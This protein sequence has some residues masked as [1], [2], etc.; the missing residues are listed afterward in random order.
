VV[1]HQ[2]TI[3]IPA[4]GNPGLKGQS[5]LAQPSG[6]GSES[7]ESFFDLKRQDKKGAALKTKANFLFCKNSISLYLLM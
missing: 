3:I 6:L 7:P 4:I 1:S 2:S 5:N